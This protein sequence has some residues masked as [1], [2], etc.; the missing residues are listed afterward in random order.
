MFP[1]VRLDNRIKENDQMEV[2]EHASDRGYVF[3]S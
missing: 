1:C 2:L 3:F